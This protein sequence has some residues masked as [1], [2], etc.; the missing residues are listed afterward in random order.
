MG[1]DIF[2]EYYKTVI[3]PHSLLAAEPPK[4]PPKPLNGFARLQNSLIVERAVIPEA[5][6]FMGFIHADI[7]VF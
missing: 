4:A 6:D 5:D 3:L 1:K 2:D 7:T